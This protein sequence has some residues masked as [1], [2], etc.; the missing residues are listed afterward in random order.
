MMKNPDRIEHLSM[1]SSPDVPN[2]RHPRSERLDWE[3][4]QV[5]YNNEINQYQRKVDGR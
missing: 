2:E 1:P 5:Q 3:M 4:Q